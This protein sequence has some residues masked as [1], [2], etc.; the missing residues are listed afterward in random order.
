MYK[1]RSGQ[2]RGD[3]RIIPPLRNRPH[4]DHV[5]SNWLFRWGDDGGGVGEGWG[6]GGGGVV[7]ADHSPVRERCAKRRV[8]CLIHPPYSYTL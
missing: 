2:E 4:V 8:P 3:P 5:D 6:R 7:S 1:N